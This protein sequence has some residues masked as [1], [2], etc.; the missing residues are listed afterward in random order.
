MKG[1]EVEIGAQMVKTATTNFSITAAISPSNFSRFLRFY[2]NF[3]CARVLR[4]S[5]ESH[6][7][8][9][10]R[11]GPLTPDSPENA[12]CWTF[13]ESWGGRQR[14]SFGGKLTREVIGRNHI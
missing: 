14:W 4:E 5:R 1:I 11:A 7:E 10:E 12:L 6:Y 8:E 2:S 13:I 3:S 9:R